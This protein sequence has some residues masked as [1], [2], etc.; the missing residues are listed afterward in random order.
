MDKDKFT[1]L[2]HGLQDIQNGCRNYNGLWLFIVVDIYSETTPT[3]TATLTVGRK[4]HSYTFT[5]D[6][7]PQKVWGQLDDLHKR[8]RRIPDLRDIVKCLKK[9]IKKK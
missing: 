6:D 5:E 7:D 2:L 3:I 8:F 9:N 1:D 4:K